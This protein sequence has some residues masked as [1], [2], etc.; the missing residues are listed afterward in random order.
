MHIRRNIGTRTQS[1]S[2]LLATPKRRLT[3]RFF[4]GHQ[5]T[6][7]A[8]LQERTEA[9]FNNFLSGKVYEAAG[10]AKDTLELVDRDFHGDAAFYLPAHSQ[11]VDIL[12]TLGQV[13]QAKCSVEKVHAR[14]AGRLPEGGP[15]QA[16]LF[17]DEAKI[18]FF[19]GEFLEAARKAKI[20]A[21][22][23]C[24]RQDGFRDLAPRA[25]SRLSESQLVLGKF[26]EAEA[27]IRLAIRLSKISSDG[28][29]ARE[30][31]YLF[32]LVRILFRQGRHREAH[33][34]LVQ[35]ATANP[36]IEKNR[37][38]YFYEWLTHYGIALHGMQ[39]LDEAK[40][41]FSRALE[42]RQG[43]QGENTTGTLFLLGKLVQIAMQQNQWEKAEELQTQAVRVSLKVHG[44]E[45]FQVSTSLK[46][47]A[48]LLG[49]NGKGDLA[50]QTEVQGQ[51]VEN[52]FMEQT[53]QKFQDRTLFEIALFNVRHVVK[54]S[55]LFQ[56]CAAFFVDFAN[57]EKFCPD[58][59]ADRQ[60]QFLAIEKHLSDAMVVQNVIA[61]QVLNF[62]TMGI[63]HSD[64]DAKAAPVVV[65]VFMFVCTSEGRKKNAETL[66]GTFIH[67]ASEL[68]E[69]EV[70]PALPLYTGVKKL[71]AHLASEA[72]PFFARHG[73]L[74][75]QKDICPG[76]LTSFVWLPVASLGLESVL[77]N[78]ADEVQAEV[79]AALGR[80]MVLLQDEL[81]LHRD[82]LEY[83]FLPLSITQEGS[84]GFLA[85]GVLLSLTV[86]AK[87][88]PVDKDA[89]LKRAA[90][91]YPRLT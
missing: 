7:V 15:L 41:T 31:C 44:P 86:A 23:F 89:I 46:N 81:L 45:S 17:C 33:D 77:K 49:K 52:K 87:G 11:W 72:D 59:K 68:Y 20:A 51:A 24:N 4:S 57:I 62:A 27:N 56:F 3:A 30:N 70:R 34:C 80:K 69:D 83:T 25:L 18:H 38:L 2:R 1:I 65:A 82:N 36:E 10:V 88:T 79:I 9:F 37:P 66:K 28:R 5:Q 13:Q 90:E 43:I 50:A 32:I 91:L 85:Q 42:M 75:T 21:E 48:R 35:H 84:D 19:S 58:P 67:L 8:L 16:I 64:T 63:Y 47:L 74:Y 54:R 26:G 29:G 60:Q 12:L 22:I 53:V 14:Y 76:S 40:A 73:R 61:A 55:P 39:H 78:S 6:L 71:Q